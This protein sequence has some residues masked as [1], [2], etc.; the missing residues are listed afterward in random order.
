M[1]NGEVESKEAMKEARSLG[2]TDYSFRQAKKV[3]RIESF[4]KGF[5]ESKWYL[6]LP[7]TDLVEDVEF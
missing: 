3:L 6:K 7:S 4:K 1:K 5:D 2:I